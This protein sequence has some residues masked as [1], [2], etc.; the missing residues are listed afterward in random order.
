MNILFSGI[1]I[2]IIQTGFYFQTG[3]DSD[4]RSSKSIN[5]LKNYDNPVVSPQDVLFLVKHSQSPN[6]VVYQANR[7]SQKNLDDKNPI[8]VFW[9][10]NSKGKKTESLTMLEWKFAYGFKIISLVKGK[11]Y[12][13]TLNA[14]KNKDITIIEDQNGKVEGFMTL[15]GHFCKLKDVFIKYEP[16]FYFPDVKYL[17]LTGNDTVTGKSITERV[18][19][20]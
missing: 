16:T 15:N 14:I 7:T 11:K 5:T 19:P 20:E 18:L 9:L 6:V 2:I 4:I 17:D 1:L 8:D 10:M 3:F 12:K 13:I